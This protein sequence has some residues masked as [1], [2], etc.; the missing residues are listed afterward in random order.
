MMRR[1]T[2]NHAQQTGTQLL[3]I[4]TPSPQH[5]QVARDYLRTTPLPDIEDWDGDQ[6]EGWL[7]LL[8]LND[9]RMRDTVKLK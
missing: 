4:A 3:S 1:G 9:R 8:G 6:Y 2:D 5:R 7:D